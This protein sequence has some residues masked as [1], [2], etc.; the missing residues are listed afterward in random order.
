MH[1]LSASMITRVSYRG[2]ALESRQLTRYICSNNQ[3]IYAIMGL[4][5]WRIGMVWFHHIEYLLFTALV[6]FQS[7][8]SNPVMLAYD[9]SRR[10]A[11]HQDTVVFA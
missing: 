5:R 6:P 3:S 2:P 4:R 1:K 11:V 7:A 8:C 9:A 10:T